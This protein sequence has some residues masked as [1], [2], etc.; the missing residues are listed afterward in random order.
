MHQ[1]V[2]HSQLKS[3]ASIDCEPWVIFKNDNF[4]QIRENLCKEFLLSFYPPYPA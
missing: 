2:G 1:P 3:I 4:N